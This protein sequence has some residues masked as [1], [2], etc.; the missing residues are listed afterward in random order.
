MIAEVASCIEL[1]CVRIRQRISRL[2]GENDHI[3]R[4]SGKEGESEL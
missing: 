1:F 2:L 4:D 3:C